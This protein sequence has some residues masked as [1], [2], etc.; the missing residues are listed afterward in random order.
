MYKIDFDSRTGIVFE[1]TLLNNNIIKKC[2]ISEEQI[3]KYF[4]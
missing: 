2:E 3:L 1:N 4:I